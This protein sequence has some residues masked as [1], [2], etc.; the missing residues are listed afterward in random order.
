MNED[1][2]RLLEKYHQNYEYEL[3]LHPKTYEEFKVE[4][5]FQS[6]I[7]GE[8][9]SILGIPVVVIDENKYP[10]FPDEYAF[11]VAAKKRDNK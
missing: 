8:L 5:E 7:L 10:D 3:Y 4:L 2:K 1:A 6:G 11:L 9:K